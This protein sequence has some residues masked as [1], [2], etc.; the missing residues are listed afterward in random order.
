MR[1]KVSEMDQSYEPNGF[2]HESTFGF[3]ND[4]FSLNLLTPRF[5]DLDSEKNFN[6]SDEVAINQKIGTELNEDL[7]FWIGT[8]E[9]VKVFNQNWVLYL[10]KE[11]ACV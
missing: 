8:N 7:E 11:K 3:R 6:E 2:F 4:A 10:D 1:G 5:F 9:N